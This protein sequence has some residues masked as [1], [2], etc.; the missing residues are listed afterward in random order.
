MAESP[1]L[2]DPAFAA[3]L[4]AF[5]LRYRARVRGSLVGVR[6]SH[7]RGSGLEFAEYRPYVLGDDVRRVD[8]RVYARLEQLVVRLAS[9]ED[10]LE[11]H[12]L[13]DAS[14][15]M[16][17]GTPSKLLVA[18]KVL[19]T[20]G[21]VALVSNERVSVLPFD[22]RLRQIVPLGRSRARLLPLLRALEVVQA[23]GTTDLDGTVDAFL[24]RRARPGLVVLA[25]DLLDPKGF[26]RPLR[27]LRSSSHEILV[28]HTLAEEELRPTPGGD[29]VFVDSERDQRVEISLD[30]ETLL[31]YGRKLAAFLT[32]VEDG[33][34]RLGHGYVRL[35][36]ADFEEP[37]LAA[38][39]AR[40]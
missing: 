39:E 33:C 34:R 4:E 9:L 8:W 10:D 23:E 26:E 15:S 40:R 24:A 28:V 11:V 7:R 14:A 5:A 16:T 20:L 25:S 3:R 1:E 29:F 31:T 17:F 30:H 12:L 27:R 22:A 13:L 35:E 19:A 21:F 6:R 36:S 38:L 2:L 18:K 32:A 37:L